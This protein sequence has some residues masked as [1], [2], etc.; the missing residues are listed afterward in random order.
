M[1]Y[2]EIYG[3]VDEAYVLVKAKSIY[4]NG[5]VKLMVAGITRDA[6][7]YLDSIK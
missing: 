3:T 4:A 2:Y 6:K 7:N 5:P 1:D